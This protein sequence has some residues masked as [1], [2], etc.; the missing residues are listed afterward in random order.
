MINNILCTLSNLTPMSIKKIYSNYNEPREK[1]YIVG[2][3]W[4]SY[5]FAKNLNKFKYEPIIIAPNSQIL[6][7]PK[8]VDFV[9]DPNTN[10]EFPNPYG[11]LI[12]DVVDDIDIDNK[13]LVTRT[14]SK[15]DYKHVVFAIG[16]EPN[17]FGIS[18]V[19]DYTYKFKTINDAHF[20]RNILNRLYTDS[21]IYIVGSGITGIELTTKM[22]KLKG[23][24]RVNF[25]LMDGL[26]KILPGFNDKTI[27]I[28]EKEIKNSHSNIE[29]ILNSMV[30]SIVKSNQLGNM[31]LNYENL[32]NG[33]N[34]KSYSL[35][36]N[37]KYPESDI[38]IWTGG[39]RF[40]GFGRT[41]LFHTLNSITHIKPRGLE[42]E[43]NFSLENQS[44]I[45][46][47]GDM[48]SNQGPPTAQNAKNQALWLAEYFNSGFDTEY[49]KTNP[50]KVKSKGK[51]IHL[52]NGTYLESDYYSG[53]IPSFIVGM[54][55]LFD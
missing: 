18:G 29:I 25:R 53:F 45:Y 41:Q 49:I 20:L 51:L 39:V 4:A 21:T 9:L 26:N 35:N 15:Y 11:L 38:I 19:N 2:N 42:V 31:E 47:L 16:S 12:N 52:A 7:T 40:K 28:I 30:K 50:Y 3:G 34:L 10:V 46:C 48:V 24:N 23:F 22:S 17:D 13:Q 32:L 55:E 6:N 43:Q 27:G 8:L 14:G 37:P 5:Y 33:N 44:S 36:T 54:I 1:V